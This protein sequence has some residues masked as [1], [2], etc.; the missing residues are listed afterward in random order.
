MNTAEAAWLW[1]SRRYILGNPT[2]ARLR[3]KWS[4][5]NLKGVIGI[6]HSHD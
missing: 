4:D 5:Q 2:P 6:D 1:Q 3:N